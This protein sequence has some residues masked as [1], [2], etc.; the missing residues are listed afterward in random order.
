MRVAVW[1]K[2]RQYPTTVNDKRL[3]IV[4]D[5]DVNITNSGS[6]T[7]TLGANNLTITA[8]GAVVGGSGTIAADGEISISAGGNV[9]FTSAKAAPV[10]VETAGDVSITQSTG[11][12]Q[13]GQVKGANIT[14]SADGNMVASSANQVGQNTTL[15]GNYHL[16]SDGNLTFSAANATEIGSNSADGGITIKSS[17]GMVQTSGSDAGNVYLELDGSVNLGNV[18]NGGE[19][20]IQKMSGAVQPL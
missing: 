6:G 8:D 12:L 4:S 9:T 18:T 3:N 15:D 16:E 13:I 14:L 5:G 20:S 10:F 19:L 17:G 11:D 7:D 1:I 2:Y